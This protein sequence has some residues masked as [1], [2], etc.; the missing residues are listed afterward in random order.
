[1]FY[2]VLLRFSHSFCTYFSLCLSLLYSL[3]ESYFWVSLSSC[4]TIYLSLPFE[5]NTVHSFL[6]LYF[7]LLFIASLRYVLFYPPLWV[8][9][10]TPLCHSSLFSALSSLSYSSLF[11]ALRLISLFSSILSSSLSSPLSFSSLLLY[12]FPSLPF[13]PL[14]YPSNSSMCF[15]V[16]IALGPMCEMQHATYVTYIIVHTAPFTFLSPAFCPLFQF[17]NFFFR[18]LCWSKCRTFKSF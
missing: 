6:S 17:F 3:A 13:S 16:N 8:I 18:P 4:L 7:L 9:Y 12:L 1:M 2:R 5:C 15:V 10:V 11:S 14:L